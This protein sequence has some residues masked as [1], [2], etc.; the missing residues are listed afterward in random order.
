MGMPVKTERA[1]S[2]SFRSEVVFDVDPFPSVLVFSGK[3]SHHNITISFFVVLIL[4]INN[5]LIHKYIFN[6]FCWSLVCFLGLLLSISLVH[7]S[8]Y[9]KQKNVETLRLPKILMKVLFHSGQNE[10]CLAKSLRHTKWNPTAPCVYML[11]PVN[12]AAVEMSVVDPIRSESSQRRFCYNHTSNF[13]AVI[14]TIN[15]IQKRFRMS[16][17]ILVIFVFFLAK[18]LIKRSQ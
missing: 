12:M 18:C 5:K 3:K 10:F 2:F 8:H 4:A 6:H 17:I 14:V 15:G 1:E 16:S 11:F 7:S 13:V 9:W